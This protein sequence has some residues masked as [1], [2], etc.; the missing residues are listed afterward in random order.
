MD[1][2][3]TPSHVTGERTQRLQSRVHLV[4]R[5]ARIGLESTAHVAAFRLVYNVQPQW[6]KV[7]ITCNKTQT[8]SA[9]RLAL[10]GALHLPPLTAAPAG[11]KAPEKDLE[12]RPASLPTSESD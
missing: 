5:D 7:L 4:Y 11:L 12:L 6:E 8:Y 1:V 3:L 2:Q 10:V 9:C